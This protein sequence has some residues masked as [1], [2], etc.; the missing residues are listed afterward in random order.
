MQWPRG[1]F[2]GYAASPD[3]SIASSELSTAMRYV[4]DVKTSVGLIFD[5]EGS[6]LPNGKAALDEAY[7]IAREFIGT[8][9]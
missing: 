2:V 1:L 7:L 6:E 3:V 5:L 9:L 8:Q 4:F